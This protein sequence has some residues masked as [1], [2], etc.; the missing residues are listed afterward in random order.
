MSY[1]NVLE[2]IEKSLKNVELLPETKLLINNYI[3][4]IRR[5]IVEDQKLVDICK[6]IYYKHQKALELIMKNK[7]DEISEVADIIKNWINIKKD[8]IKHDKIDTKYLIRFRTSE[9][10]N[11]IPESEEP[12]S[13]WKTK[14]HYFYEITIK[15][16]EDL[17]CC[18]RFVL[19]SQKSNSEQKELF[20][21]INELYP[22][23]N[24]K[25]DWDYRCHFTTSSFTIKTKEISEEKIYEKLDK[26]LLEILAFQKELI[27]K[28]K[29]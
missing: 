6:K 22:V 13:G 20:E 11:I 24:A 21:K 15:G 1:Q 7:P 12:N 17:N 26:A 18:I 14:N 3:E 23:K 19:S 16:K 5:D 29:I 10:D 8:D 2:I 25:D 28:I 27:S 4:I 9:M